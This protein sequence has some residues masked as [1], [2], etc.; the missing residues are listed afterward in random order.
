MSL[1]A[2]SRG[3][4]SAELD[5]LC[6]VCREKSPTLGQLLPGIAPRDQ[7]LLTAVLSVCFCHPIP[8]PG[9]STLCGLII[10]V[11]GGRMALGKGPWIPQRWHGRP[12]PGPRLA[13]VFAGG[14]ALMRRC[15][16]V[17][18]P[19]GLWLS[20]QPWTQRLNGGAIAFCGLLLAAPAPPGTAMPPAVA[21]LLL[22][23]GTLER[24]LLFLAAGYAALALNI[25]FFGAIALLGWSGVKSLLIR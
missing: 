11:A 16:K 6:A 22:S 12:L 7:A 1:S 3:R 5:R 8:L 14:A 19:R 23:I 24:D 20:D 21:I 17:I 25:A 2:A 9:L 10:T 18:G 13:K 15:E 4:L